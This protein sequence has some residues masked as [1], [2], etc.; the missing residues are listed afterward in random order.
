MPKPAPLVR[1]HEATFRY[2]R[3]VALDGVSIAVGPGDFVGIRGGDG[4][5]KTTLLRALAGTIPPRSGK[6]IGT[7]RC[8]YVPAALDPPPLSVSQ[9][10]HGIRNHAR[11]PL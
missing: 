5:G 3:F 2:G 8:A 6:R 9:W 11:N 1:L 10:V 4:F 7:P